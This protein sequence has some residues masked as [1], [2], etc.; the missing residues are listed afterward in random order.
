MPII[1]WGYAAMHHPPPF[2]EAFHL[3][4]N[5]KPHAFATLRREGLHLGPNGTW[6]A[7]WAP[8]G[9]PVLLFLSA[10][11][12]PTCALKIEDKALVR[13]RWRAAGGPSECHTSWDRTSKRKTEELGLRDCRERGFLPS[14][15]CAGCILPEWSSRCEPKMRSEWWL[16]AK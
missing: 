5:T 13:R 16:M 3:A 1:L 14:G 11:S 6:A 2:T 15:F 7:K 10:L 4:Q 12:Q 9:R 8:T